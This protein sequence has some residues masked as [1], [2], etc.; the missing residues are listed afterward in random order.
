M[1]VTDLVLFKNNQFIAL[2]K[3]AG[4][5]VQDD[6][7]E[8]SSLHGIARAYTKSDV[9]LVH[10]IDR[11]ASGIVLF[12]KTKNAATA[13]SAQ[14]R[15]RSVKKTYLAAVK[16]APPQPEGTIFHYITHDKK[17]NKSHVYDIPEPG[18]KRAELSFK[19]L[20]TTDN[21]TILEIDLLTG[22][23]HQIRAQLAALGSPIKGDVKYG[24]RRANKDRGIHLH[25][26]KLDFEHPVS[27]EPVQIEAEPPLEDAIWQLMR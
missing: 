26:W 5:P 1:Q 6:E 17:R 9:Y 23:H 24:A 27:G 12:A 2:N 11:P 22:R 15:A 20:R 4:M 13:I 25:A 3:P 18:S 10:R 14:F 16:T 19:T 7:S 8:D 21:Y